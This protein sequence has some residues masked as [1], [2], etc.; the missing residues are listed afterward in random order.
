MLC[1]ALR[2][3][4]LF[5]SLK[6]SLR[7]LKSH[8]QINHTQMH[9]SLPPLPKGTF[10]QFN[11]SEGAATV[12]SHKANSFKLLCPE[13]TIH[14]LSLSLSQSFSNCP[15]FFFTKKESCDLTV[16]FTFFDLN[17]LVQCPRTH[18]LQ[19]LNDL[20]VER[21]LI[22]VVLHHHLSSL[23]PSLIPV[24]HRHPICV[25]AWTNS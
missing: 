16:L 1:L 23:E 13:N 3:I 14:S 7:L 18:L 9:K 17:I 25:D 10:W 4:R 22:A 12:I 15:E 8:A 24:F 21:Q 11:M 6:N 19:K 5:F 2:H 20:N